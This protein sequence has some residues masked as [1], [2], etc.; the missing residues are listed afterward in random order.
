LETK[1]HDFVSTSAFR[2]FTRIKNACAE[3]LICN[4]GFQH[5]HFVKY[6]TT[7]CKNMSR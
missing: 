5:Q 1:S 2:I 3:I 7:V 4:L 6:K